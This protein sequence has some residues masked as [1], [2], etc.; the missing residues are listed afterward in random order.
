MLRPLGTKTFQE[1]KKNG[2][3]IKSKNSSKSSV[4]LNLK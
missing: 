4:L 3:S 1:R 2:K